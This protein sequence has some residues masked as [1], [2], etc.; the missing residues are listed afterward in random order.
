TPNPPV[1]VT[2]SNTPTSNV[3]SPF[4]ALPSPATAGIVSGFGAEMP[5]RP[6]APAPTVTLE[7]DVVLVVWSGHTP[8]AALAASVAEARRLVEAQGRAAL[9]MLD[10]RFVTSW[11][12]GAI[13][14]AKDLLQ[15]VE[16]RAKSVAIVVGS[17]TARAVV[18]VALKLVRGP[19]ASVF[20]SREEALA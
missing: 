2:P 6:E 5:A 16:S 10:A 18:S 1:V 15:S 8:T 19:R 20:V 13:T 14:E 17:G 7:G 9:V 11:E 3:V 12:G 4:G